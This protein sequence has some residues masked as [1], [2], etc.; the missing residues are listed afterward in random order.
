M[1]KRLDTNHHISEIM[2]R[3]IKSHCC[4][5][6]REK[7]N[8]NSQG[9]GGQDSQADD[10]QDH[11]PLV[12]LGV[13]VQQL[14]L[15]VLCDIRQHSSHQNNI[16]VFTHKMTVTLILFNILLLADNACLSLRPC[17]GSMSQV[18][19]SICKYAVSTIFWKAPTC[20]IPFSR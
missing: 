14:R 9:H 17:L 19:N 5:T 20:I 10:Q 8:W 4:Y 1:G 15:H 18:S 6:Y 3:L 16:L 12:H 7:H 11:V 2:Q 13:G